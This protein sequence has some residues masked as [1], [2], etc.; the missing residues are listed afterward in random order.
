MR[1]GKGSPSFLPK[2]YFYLGICL[3]GFAIRAGFFPDESMRWHYLS[4]FFFLIHVALIR[5]YALRT[6]RL[7]NMYQPYE[8]GL[9]ARMTVQLSLGALLVLGL[10]LLWELWFQLFFG[11][12]PNRTSRLFV[13]VLDMAAMVMF[14]LVFIGRHFLQ[15]WKE[16][17]VKTEIL[18]KESAIFQ[19]ENLKNQMNPHFLFN[20]LTSLNSLIYDNQELASQFLQ[21]LSK[22]YRY[23][24]LNKD[25]DLVSVQEE[26]SFIHNY[27]SL[28]KTRFGEGLQ[29][30]FDIREDEKKLTIVPVT[31]QVLIE[32][33]IKHN[34]VGEQYPLK[35]N[36]F[37]RNKYLVVENNIQRKSSVETSNKQGLENMK[38]LYR[39]ISDRE[40]EVVDTGNK[41]VVIV[42]L[43]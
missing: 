11:E 1:K 34:R 40:L 42:P 5:E 18:Q 29:I 23:L 37:T 9:R 8:K 20:S 17:L 3:V 22:V 16:T 32:N 4:N 19:F 13:F 41:F 27:V 26:T 38:Q 12:S 2:L 35:I 39:F 14:T 10:L 43:V 6:D 36:I 28:L 21:Q 7:L 30:Q 24:L 15:A 31:L 25:N 33:A